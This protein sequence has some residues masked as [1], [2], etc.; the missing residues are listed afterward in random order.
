LYSN[1]SAV[2]QLDPDGGKP[3]RVLAGMHIGQ[4]AAL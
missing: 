2:Y 1:G 4:I 3:R